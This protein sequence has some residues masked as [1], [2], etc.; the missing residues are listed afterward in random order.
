[1]TFDILG[2]TLGVIATICSIFFGIR[3]FNRN[4]DCDVKQSASEMATFKSMLIDIK[5]NVSDIKREMTSLRA[6]NRQLLERVVAT[7]TR[8]SVLDREFQDVKR[9]IRGLIND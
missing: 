3:A 6:E 8:L 1:M 5:D 9:N 2:W 7:E 4:R